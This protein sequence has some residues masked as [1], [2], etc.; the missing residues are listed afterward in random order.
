MHTRRLRVAFFLS[1]LL[2]TANNVVYA[3]TKHVIRI[4][5]TNPTSTQDLMQNIYVF[6]VKNAK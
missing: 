3:T 5:S 6:F 1:A 2:G 4:I